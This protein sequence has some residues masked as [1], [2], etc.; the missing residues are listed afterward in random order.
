[1]GGAF[2]IVAIFRLYRLLQVATGYY[3]LLHFTVVTAVIPFTTVTI[4]NT[5]TSLTNAC[6]LYFGLTPSIYYNVLC[7]QTG[8]ALYNS[9]NL[10][11]NGFYSNLVKKLQ[12]LM[13]YNLNS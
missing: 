13:F 9:N 3:R 4:V 2:V 1:M 7:S 10:L 8:S 12:F 5:V 11:K 6:T